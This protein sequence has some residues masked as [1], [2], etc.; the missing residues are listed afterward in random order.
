VN[1]EAGCTV[2][3][4]CRPLAEKTYAQMSAGPYS[5]NCSLMAVPESFDAYLAAH[6]TA[7]KRAL[8]CARLGYTF[9]EID[10]LRARR[11]DLPDQH[12]AP[13]AARTADERR[14]P[15]SATSFRRCRSTRA[16][17]TGS[18]STASPHPTASSSRTPSSHRV[19]ELVMVSQI[20]GHGEHL[21]AGIIFLL[22]SESVRCQITAGA[23]TVF[24]N[25]HDSGSDGLRWNK[26]HLG[27]QPGD[28]EWLLA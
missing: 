23:G 1:L 18:A 13:R 4:D 9:A 3:T 14:I 25:R 11:R 22:V 17:V 2:D 5:H 10:R 27:F 20:L 24:Y 28:V 19:G 8:R 16:H 6:R 21:D 26:E 15:S 12:V 7:R